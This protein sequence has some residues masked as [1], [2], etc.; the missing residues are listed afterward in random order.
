MNSIE[1]FSNKTYLELSLFALFVFFLSVLYCS[2]SNKYAS[3]LWCLFAGILLEFIASWFGYGIST[4]Q[5]EAYF[6]FLVFV[7]LLIFL[8]ATTF[9]GIAASNFLVD[10]LENHNIT[11]SLAGFVLVAISYFVFISPNGMMV[12][13][14]RFVFP[15]VGFLYLAVALYSK[16]AQGLGFKFAALLNSFASL[17]I[18]LEIFGIECFLS[19]QWYIL[20][21]FYIAMSFALIIIKTDYI[22]NKLKD[23]HQKIQNSNTQI[24]NIIKASPFPIVISK[25]SDDK[26]LVANNNAVKLFG[27]RENELERYKLKDFF[28]DQDNRKSLN[29][30]LE[31]K[32]EVKDFEILVKSATGNTPFWLLTSANTIDYNHDVAVYLAFQDITSRKNR[33]VLLKN[34]ATRDPLTSLFNR[35]YFEEETQQRISKSIANNSYFAVFMLDVD[36]FKNVND[37]YGHKV[38]DNVLIEIATTTVDALRNNDIVAR[39]GGEEFVV[40]VNVSDQDKAFA[41]AE[42]LRETIAAIKIPTDNAEETISV[43]IS[44]G[45]AT[46]DVSKDLGT[47]VKMADTALYK[48]KNNGRNRCEFFETEM[49]KQNRCNESLHPLF[50]KEE[51]QEIS[52]LDGVEANHIF[53]SNNNIENEKEDIYNLSINKKEE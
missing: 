44:I 7:E 16:S 1:V 37:T 14:L 46:S 42:R 31:Q 15:L 38:G 27:I 52:L 40:F 11:L 3:S 12:N 25:L 41:V 9:M 2:K 19:Y 20:P 36:K 35:R 22:M 17:S 53:S 51:N 32:G 48:A 6:N 13:N 49:V 45:I 26:V 18:I 30:K 10:K 24:E 47:L 28:I 4:Y 29:E 33:E 21:T 23:S 34:Q 43:T 8:G 50:E 39:Y 5:K